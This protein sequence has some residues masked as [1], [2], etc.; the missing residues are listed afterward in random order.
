MPMKT[1]S[2]I[3]SDKVESEGSIQDVLQKGKKVVLT[4]AEILEGKFGKYALITLKDGAK[5]HIVNT[6]AV[7]LVQS[8]QEMIS[9]GL[10]DGDTFK[11]SLAS[12]MSK[13][14]REY[15]IFE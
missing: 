14:D 15:L 3:T 1:I 10:G 7:A 4:N 6:S 8:C 13:D 12:K 2:D 11:V 9:N 5:E